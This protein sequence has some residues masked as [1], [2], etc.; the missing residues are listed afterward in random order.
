MKFYT[1]RAGDARR[2]VE[3]DSFGADDYYLGEGSG[4]ADRYVVEGSKVEQA[5]AMDATTYERWVAGIDV[6]SGKPKGGCGPTRTR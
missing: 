6:E 5:S 3:A 4:V 1:G 2:Y